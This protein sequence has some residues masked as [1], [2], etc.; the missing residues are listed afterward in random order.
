MALVPGGLT[1]L[2]KKISVVEKACRERREGAVKAYL[3]NT[4]NSK[5]RAPTGPS[6]AATPMGTSQT[7]ALL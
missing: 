6:E 1:D 4:V 2:L 7:S 3:G 5:V